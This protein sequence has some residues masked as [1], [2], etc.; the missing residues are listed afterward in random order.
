MGRAMAGAFDG[1][2]VLELTWG[3]AGP[4]TG[5]MLADQ[6]ALVTRIEPPHD[7][8]TPHAGSRVWNRGQRSAVI[9]LR[10]PA[11]RQAFLALADR[12]D[13]VLDSFRPGVLERLGVGPD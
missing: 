10:D 12:A 3:I 8:F 5:M 9:D 11:A 2:S 4:M 7:P 1:L 13:I 6:G